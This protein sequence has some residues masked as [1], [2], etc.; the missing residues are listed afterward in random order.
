MKNIIILVFLTVSLNL[1]SQ[2][3]ITI[4]GKLFFSEEFYRNFSNLLVKIDDADE[5]VKIEEDGIFEIKTSTKKENYKLIFSY[6]SI[7]FKEYNYKFEWTKR[8]KPKSISLAENCRINKNIAQEDFREKRKLKLYVYN[9][10]DTLILSKKDKRVQK[11]TN[12]EFVKM[13]YEDLNKFECI[14]D[15]NKRVF[16]ILYLSGKV[17]FLK[18]LRKDVISYNY[19]YNR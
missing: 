12:S 5:Y 11:K 15:Y 6:G 16:K 3:I 18:N 2:E 8:Y 9:K 7:K 10:L 13:S 17:K 14:S 1:F 19:R 4:K